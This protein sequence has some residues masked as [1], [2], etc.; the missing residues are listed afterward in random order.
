MCKQGPR[1]EWRLKNSI[2]IQ[3]LLCNAAHNGSGLRSGEK[4]KYSIISSCTI[5]WYYQ[6]KETKLCALVLQ[7]LLKPCPRN[8]LI[9]LELFLPKVLSS[10]TV[11]PSNHH[12]VTTISL[13]GVCFL[14]PDIFTLQWNTEVLKMFS[15]PFVITKIQEYKFEKNIYT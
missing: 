12:F 6:V 14:I 9:L 5:T 13:L 4:C 3:N 8:S 15:L 10:K 1:T 2:F 11:M 7:T